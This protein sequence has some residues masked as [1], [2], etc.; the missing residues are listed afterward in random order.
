MGVKE[1]RI[2]KFVDACKIVKNLKIVD[3]CEI[4]KN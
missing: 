1:I 3:G 4:D 2:D